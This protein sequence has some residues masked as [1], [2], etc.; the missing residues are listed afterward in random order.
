MGLG[1]GLVD[2]TDW[3]LLNQLPIDHHVSSAF[4]DSRVL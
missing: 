3:L 4:R 1:P 2:V